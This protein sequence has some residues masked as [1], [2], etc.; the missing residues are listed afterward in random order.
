MIRA[1]LLNPSIASQRVNV[2]AEYEVIRILAF[3][4]QPICTKHLL[5]K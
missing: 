2:R 3:E 5:Q 1:K 4:L